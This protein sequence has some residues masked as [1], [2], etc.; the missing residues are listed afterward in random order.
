MPDLRVRAVNVADLIK[1]ERQTEQLHGLSETPFLMRFPPRTSASSSSSV[2]ARGR[3]VSGLS[4]HCPSQPHVR[5]GK[6]EGTMDA[7]DMTVLNDLGR[8][9]LV[10][11]AIDR[12][13]QTGDKK[14]PVWNNTSG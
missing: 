1:L 6:E 4:L 8:F 9:L 7:F 14:A 2:A 10:M 11:N 3:L 12:L 13:P 5:D